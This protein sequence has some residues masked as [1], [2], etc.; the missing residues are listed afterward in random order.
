M[1][2]EINN[3]IKREP[4]FPENLYSYITK[5]RINKNE[6]TCDDNIHYAVRIAEHTFVSQKVGPLSYIMGSIVT[7][8]GI[9]G[10]FEDACGDEGEEGCTKLDFIKENIYYEMEFP[11]QLSENELSDAAVYF[12]TNLP[13]LSQK[14][15]L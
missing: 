13:L 14:Q 10:V 5:R 4:K 2:I 1:K 9:I 6:F 8:I 11:W 15:I 7:D 12:V 3:I